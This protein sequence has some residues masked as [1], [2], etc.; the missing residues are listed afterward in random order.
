MRKQRARLL[1]HSQKPPKQGTKPC[2]CAWSHASLI[3]SGR[4]DG[5]E[6]LNDAGWEGL[7]S[8]EARC[9]VGRLGQQASGAGNA[10]CDEAGEG[11]GAAPEAACLSGWAL[12]LSFPVTSPRPS[13]SVCSG[14][15]R[16]GSFPEISSASHL[17]PHPPLFAGVPLWAGAVVLSGLAASVV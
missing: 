1:K 17:G 3:S 14:W 9:V 15:R 2:F 11:M 16:P 4:T 6:L 7:G 5:T 10:S 13:S 8:S 12:Q